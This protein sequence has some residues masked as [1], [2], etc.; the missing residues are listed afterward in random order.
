MTTG[1]RVQKAGLTGGQRYTISVPALPNEDG[2]VSVLPG[3]KDFTLSTGAG[4]GWDRPGDGAWD[5]NNPNDFYFTTTAAFTEHSRLWRLHF[6]DIDNPTAGGTVELVLEGPATGPGGPRMMDN[7][8]VTERGQILIQED[9]GN[10]LYLAGVYQYDIATQTL[11]RVADH[12]PER[13]LPGGSVFDT[14]DEESSGIIPAP[15]LGAGK[16]RSTFKTIP[17]WRTRSWWRRDNFSLWKAPTEPAKRRSRGVRSNQL[18]ATIGV[19]ES[20]QVDGDHPP[21]CRNAAPDAKEGPEAFGPHRQQQY[22]VCES[23]LDVSS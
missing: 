6:N 13:F 5:P 19:A 21:A 10:Q 17:T 2:A 23:A 22:G 4:A 18:R 7:I 16:Y 15:F 14:V 11:N 9:P 3:P 20:R 8:T 12:D 1:N